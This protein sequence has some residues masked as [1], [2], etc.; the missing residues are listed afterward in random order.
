MNELFKT[1]TIATRASSTNDPLMILLY[2]VGCLIAI[3]T[4][5]SLLG[6]VLIYV[7]RKVAAHFQCRLGPMR[8]GPH[9]ILQSI[10][11]GLKLLQKEDIVPF[12]ADAFLHVGAPFFAILA[13]LLSLLIIPMSPVV[14]ILDLNIGVLYLTGVGGF[15]VL[16]ILVGGWS[17][18]N[19]WSLIGAMRAGAQIISYEISA[20]LAL[21]VIVL[22]AGSLNLTKIIESQASGWWVWR[23]HGI[24]LVAFLMFFVSGTAEINRTPFD[25]PEGESELGGGFHT[26]Y[27][28][29][30][31]GLFFLAEFIN[32]F[33]MC[34]LASTL[35]LGGWMPF[36]IGDWTAFNQTMDL[37]PAGL[38]FTVKTSFLI[39]VLMWFRWTFPRLRVDQL[40]TLEWKILLPIGFINLIVATLVCYFNFY[41]FP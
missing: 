17:S 24:G 23:A 29:L 33:I 7:E 1:V 27:S 26:E 28:G 10:A 22:F 5:V 19:K 12:K 14:N 9:G 18:N 8:V 2:V 20:T 37:I 15:G 38:W 31:F 36:H 40:M 30:R 41:F 13:T 34:A 3:A 4:F 35:F 32:M 25:I 6:L 11:D 21:L 16:G 39:F